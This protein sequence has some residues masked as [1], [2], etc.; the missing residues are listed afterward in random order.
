MSS[1]TIKMTGPHCTAEDL[2]LPAILLGRS[3]EC[4]KLQVRHSHAV[5]LSLADYEDRDYT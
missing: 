3:V 1:L 4:L 5:I 2:V